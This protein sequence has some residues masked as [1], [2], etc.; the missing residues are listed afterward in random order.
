[1][2]SV[3]EL[4]KELLD[5]VR[6]IIEE[7]PALS[8]VSVSILY[9][10]DFCIEECLKEDGVFEEYKEKWGDEFREITD[11]YES[12]II[13]V[14]SKVLGKPIVSFY[15]DDE[16]IM[17]FP[18]VFD[19]DKEKKL[20]DAITSLGCNIE[21]IGSNDTNY[22]FIIR[23]LLDDKVED[24]YNLFSTFVDGIEFML[25]LTNQYIYNNI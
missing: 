5:N 25:P 15:V 9:N 8:H 3:E 20:W 23:E 13:K 4:Q 24:K 7:T 2:K 12:Y 19:E 17:E 18:S 1:M 14:I 21:F 22:K 10:D 16:F 6:K 11:S